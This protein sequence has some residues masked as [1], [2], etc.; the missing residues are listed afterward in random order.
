MPL[1]PP[2]IDQVRKLDKALLKRVIQNST[3]TLSQAR[4]INAEAHLIGLA[5]VN[6]KDVADFVAGTPRLTPMSRY[7]STTMDDKE[8]IAREN[9]QFRKFANDA[10]TK[11]M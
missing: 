2:K 1:M 8:T 10:A 9:V 3:Y 4:H 7:N 6:N 11:R 5:L